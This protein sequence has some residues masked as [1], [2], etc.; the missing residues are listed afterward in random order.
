MKR[1][2]NGELNLHITVTLNNLIQWLW[3]S[4]DVK[5]GSNV[6]MGAAALSN[7]LWNQTVCL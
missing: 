6:G 1:N 3:E 7:C 2:L 4:G 5:L